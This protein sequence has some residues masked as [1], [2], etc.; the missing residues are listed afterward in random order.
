MSARKTPPVSSSIAGANSALLCLNSASSIS[1]CTSRSATGSTSASGCNNAHSA[2]ESQGFTLMSKHR[3][4]LPQQP[5][6]HLVR[7]ELL[8]L[9]LVMIA[10]LGRLVR[11]LDPLPHPRA[12]VVVEQDFV[13]GAQGGKRRQTAVLQGAGQHHL[14]VG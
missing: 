2:A 13:R 1:R 9:R 3:E 11:R 14:V 5:L 6:H 10:R 4:R 7:L 12:L 8:T